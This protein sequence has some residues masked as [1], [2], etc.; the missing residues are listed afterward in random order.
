MT[1]PD[2]AIAAP[3][4]GSVGE[5]LPVAANPSARHYYE[6]LTHA[7]LVGVAL[8]R[9]DRIA[10]LIEQERAIGAGGISMMG[11]ST[12]GCDDQWIREERE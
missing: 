3:V 10:E 4:H 2:S 12:T 8:N 1:N 11:A 7:Q 5:S 9:D 6:S